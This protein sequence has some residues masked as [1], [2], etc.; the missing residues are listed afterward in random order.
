[1]KYIFYMP[2]VLYGENYDIEDKH[3][4]YDLIRKICNAKYKNAEAPIL[5]GHGNQRRELIYIADAVDILLDN[6]HKE[7]EVINLST[8]YDYSIREYA[9]LI[10]KIVDYD[11]NLIQFDTSKY[12]GALQKKFVNKKL[13]EVNFTDLEAG[14]RKTIQYYVDNYL[15]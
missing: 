12:V 15:E 2:S 4:I 1:M 8:G 9:S 14:L 11:F 6:L 13:K 3:F 10:S 7:N 5:W